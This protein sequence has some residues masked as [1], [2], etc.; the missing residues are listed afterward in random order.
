M[1]V[2]LPRSALAI[3]TAAGEYKVYPGEHRLLFSTG[4]PGPTAVTVAV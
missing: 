2:E 1:S 3:T 4:A